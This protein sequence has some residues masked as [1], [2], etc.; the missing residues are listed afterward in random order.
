MKQLLGIYSDQD[1]NLLKRV[2]LLILTID[3]RDYKREILVQ[4]YTCS[5]RHVHSKINFYTRWVNYIKKTWCDD[6]IEN[7]LIRIKLITFWLQK[8][9][10]TIDVI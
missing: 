2:S 4:K 10:Y 9:C 6:L 7:V 5:I 8:L 3:V 1:F